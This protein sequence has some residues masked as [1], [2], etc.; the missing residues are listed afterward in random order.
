MKTKSR[1]SGISMTETVIVISTVVLLA[2]FGTPAV[3]SLLK[4]FESAGGTRVMISASFASARAIAAKEQ[5]YVGVRFQKDL[6]GNQYMIFIVQDPALG[7]Y[8]FRAV[9]G[10]KPIKLPDTVGV[11]DLMVRTDHRPDR[12][13]AENTDCESIKVEYLDDNKYIIDTT[14]FSIIFSPSGH[15]VIHDVRVRNRDGVYQPNNGGPPDEISM[16]EV[17]NSPININIY[18]IGMFIQDDYAEMGLGA[19]PSRSKFIIYNK[20]EFEK[21]NRNERWSYLQELLNRGPIY[22]NPYTGTII[23]K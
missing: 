10:I 21:K 19:E 22:I 23:G 14:T 13:G 18:K 16:D 9:E 7:A 12:W 3:N 11:M 5:R 4:S 1:Q 2:V 20:A 8:F 15:L 17:F 6:K